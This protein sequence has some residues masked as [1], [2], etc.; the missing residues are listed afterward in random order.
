MARTVIT[1]VTPNVLPSAGVVSPALN[2]T[3]IAADSGNGNQFVASGRDL[4]IVHNTDTNPQTLTI[5]SAPDLAGR[6][7]DITAYSIAAGAHLDVLITA[8]SL[9]TQ[10]DGTIQLT[11]SSSLVKFLVLSL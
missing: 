11:A 9:F 2:A 1:N 3:M 6:K 8:A 5:V 10:T 4:V 7:A